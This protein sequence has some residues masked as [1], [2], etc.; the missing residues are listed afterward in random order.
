M[1][2]SNEIMTWVFAIAM[3][4]LMFIVAFVG[5]T[6]T[7]LDNEITRHENKLTIL[8]DTISLNQEAIKTLI[9]SETKLIHRVNKLEAIWPEN[10]F[11]DLLD[12]L[13]HLN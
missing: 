3:C 8:S 6:E 7:K 9:M 4:L 13:L 10:T 1:M 2:K 5:Y 12:I 11:R